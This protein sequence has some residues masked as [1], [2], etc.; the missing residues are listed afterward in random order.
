MTL[1]E[2]FQNAAK[3][4]A[5]TAWGDREV[6][7]AAYLSGAMQLAAGLAKM[8]GAQPHP[9]RLIAAIEDAGKAL[10]GHGSQSPYPKSR[11]EA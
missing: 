7:I 3:K 2:N 5:D 4:Y 9:T 6:L 11:D 1:S 10:L 8:D